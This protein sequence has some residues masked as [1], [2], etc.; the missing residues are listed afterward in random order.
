MVMIH[1]VDDG[2]RPVGMICGVKEILILMEM[3]LE[4]SEMA[5]IIRHYS[6]SEIEALMDD[7]RIYEAYCLAAEKMAWAIFNN[8][9][10]TIEGV[11]YSPERFGLEYF[12]DVQDYDGV[13]F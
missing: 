7:R 6:D 3:G 2:Y 5:A 1:T 8:V 13:A 11:K 9:I 10:V 4:I 12:D